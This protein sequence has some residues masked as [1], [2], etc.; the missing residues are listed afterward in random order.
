MKKLLAVLVVVAFVATPAFALLNDDH[1]INTSSS[2]DAIAGAIATGGNGGIGMGGMGFGGSSSV[3]DSGNSRNDNE[4]RNTNTNVTSSRSDQ[5]QGQLQGQGQGQIAAQGQLGIVSPSQD[6]NVSEN[7]VRGE[8]LSFAAPALNAEKGT[9]PG[10][11]YSILGGVS[12]SETEEYVV[13]IEK[14]A[15]VERLEKLGYMSKEDAQAEAMKAYVQLKAAS[16]SKRWLGVG[17]RTH[18]RHLLNLFGILACDS[19]LGDRE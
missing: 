6:V 1:S 5:D 8:A 18:G 16:K 7:H 14:I 11:F 19:I 3:R 17:G 2:S 9:S 12:V 15:T 10:Q 4:N 13:C